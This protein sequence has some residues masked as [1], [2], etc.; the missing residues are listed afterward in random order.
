M[1]QVPSVPRIIGAVSICTS[2]RSRP[3]GSPSAID[4]A[5]APSERV[6]RTARRPERFAVTVTVARSL[7]RNDTRKPRLRF[8]TATRR[9]RGASVSRTAGSGAGVAIG[10]GVVL[11]TGTTDGV[12]GVAVGVAVAARAR[13]RAT[14]EAR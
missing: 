12:V 5:P 8:D 4:R 7:R 14:A 1:G 11:G 10:A 3:A 13:R 9:S 2:N 6:R